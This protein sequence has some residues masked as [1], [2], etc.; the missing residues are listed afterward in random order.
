MISE[1][2]LHGVQSAVLNRSLHDAVAKSVDRHSLPAA[3]ALAPEQRGL[4][5]ARARAARLDAVRS[6]PALCAQFIST[7]EQ[8]GIRI[9]TAQDGSE[10]ARIVAQ[11]A[12]EC[13]ATRAVKSK[14]MAT[15]EIALNE[16]LAQAGVTVLE[17]DLGEYIV[18]LAGERPSHIIAPCLHKS[19]KEIAELFSREAGREIPEDTPSLSAFARG[20][21]REEFRRADLGISGA[22]F[23]VAEDG[24]LVIISNE[25]NARFSTTL[26]R[27]HV[28]VVG[29]EKLIRNYEAMQDALRLLPVSSTGQRITSYVSVVRGPAAPGEDGPEEVHVVLMDAGRSQILGGPYEEALLCIRCG[30]CLDICPVYRQTGGHAYQSVYSGPIGAVLTPLLRDDAEAKALPFLSSLCG[31]CS[32]VCPVGIHLHEHLVALRAR[33]VAGGTAFTGEG[34]AFRGYRRAWAVPSRY[35][36]LRSLMP[37]ALRLARAGGPLRLWLRGRTL[38]P[39]A[40]APV[41]KRLRDEG[42]IE[43]DD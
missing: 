24:S 15:E 28:A 17:T 22:N 33:A 40:K 42:L 21:L 43:E 35:L 1:K 11:I 6:L 29:V 38:P 26:P 31:A 8:R 34:A 5:R 16:Q 36:R 9:H 20:R 13:G 25:G 30:A 18:Q 14:S 37:G 19:R 41:A 23:L 12:R 10:A 4:F 39:V 27:V 7:A 32:D 2:L 3:A